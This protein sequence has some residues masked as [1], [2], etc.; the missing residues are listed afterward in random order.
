MVTK[1]RAV[2]WFTPLSNN[3]LF[4]LHVNVA[5]RMEESSWRLKYNNVVFFF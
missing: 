3:S 5:R 2:K 4:S 1:L